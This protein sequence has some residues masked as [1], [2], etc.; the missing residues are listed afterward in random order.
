MY[1]MKHSS[2]TLVISPL[3]SLMDDQ[4]HG[5]PKFLRATRLHSGM[6]KDQRENVMI[7]IQKGNV[8]ILLVSPE[9]LTSWAGMSPYYSPLAKLP[10]I[11]FV[12]VDECHCLSEW[13]HS[14]RPSY[15]RVCKVLK[16]QLGIKCLV[17]LT[18]TSTRSTCISVAKQLGITDFREGMILNMSLPRNLSLSIS[19]DKYKDEAL[20]MLLSGDRF[21]NLDSV[22]IYCTRRDE[23]VRVSSYL[24]TRLQREPA[25]FE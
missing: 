15:L 4:V 19:K 25:P 16:D 7:E 17:G 24:R 21:R 18:A 12:C 5:L 6:T 20:E 3:V 10:P 22:I 11:S 23:V 9:A 2:I 13:S 14:F 1:A 8:D